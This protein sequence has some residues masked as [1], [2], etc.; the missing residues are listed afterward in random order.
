MNTGTPYIG[1]K[2]SLV[3]KAKIRYEGFLYTIDQKDST[4]TL[5]KVISCGTEDRCPH[6]PVPAREEVFEYIVFRGSDI[7]DLH[8]CEA[9]KPVEDPAIVQNGPVQHNSH[10]QSQ[11]SNQYQNSYAPFGGSNM[12]QFGYSPFFQPGHDHQNTRRQTPPS[13]P[14][15]PTP[16]P[17]KSQLKDESQSKKMDERKPRYENDRK[18]RYENDRDNKNRDHDDRRKTSSDRTRDYKDNNYRNARN[19]RDHRDYRDNHD[20]RDYRDNRD[21]RYYRDNREHDNRETNRRD[22]K[23]Y[24]QEKNTRTN[25]QDEQNSERPQRG[26][27]HRGRGRGRGNARD[28]KT[29]FTEDF[30]F[31]TSN[32]KFNKEDI[33]QELLKVLNKVKIKDDNND[34]IIEKAQDIEEK[35][36]DDSAP[37]PSPDKFYDRSKSFFDNISCEAMAPVGKTEEEPVMTRRQE[38]T[39]NC[40]TFGRGA[41]NFRPGYFRGR[42]RGRGRGGRGRGR[43]RGNYRGGYRN[44]SNRNWVDYEFDYEAAGI[45]NRNSQ[46]A[47]GS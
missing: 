15:T 46:T 38:K 34:V 21:N 42:G 8:V 27:P 39:L 10:Y 26:A 40:E 4:V 28:N 32:A 11:T 30:D 1:S 23:R 44:N 14:R 41:A 19:N 13:L 20:N 3:S 47:G 17:I 31:E 37:L 6:K 43:G 7:D 12:P 29:K 2:I 36:Q 24:S 35:D 33:E 45:R 22:N 5:A 18:P 9:P 16:D 25:T